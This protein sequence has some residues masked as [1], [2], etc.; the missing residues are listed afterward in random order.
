LIIVCGVSRIVTY[1]KTS[2]R[3][4]PL[5]GGFLVALPKQYARVSFR[6]IPGSQ[7]KII[8]AFRD[9]LWCNLIQTS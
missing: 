8:V 7:G 1:E 9:G 4:N 3:K 5:V 6:N 2:W